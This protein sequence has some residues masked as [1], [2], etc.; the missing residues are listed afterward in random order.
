MKVEIGTVIRG[1]L[2][3]EDLIPAFATLLGQLDVNDEHVGLLNDCNH[4]TSEDDPEDLITDLIEALTEFAPPY[5]YFGAH[6]GDGSD[7][8]FWV[9]IDRV[10]EAIRDG[11]L[12]CYADL[13]E[14][15][16]SST[17]FVIINDHGNCTYYT[18]TAI[19][20]RWSVV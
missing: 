10:K 14:V 8:G 17:E 16:P 13:S 5:T 2:R 11:E 7:F 20:E 18:R 9:D 3:T 19:E 4:W 12:D 1:T 15:E 6:M